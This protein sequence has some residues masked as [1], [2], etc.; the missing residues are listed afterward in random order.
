METLGEKDEITSR[1]RQDAT[2][3]PDALIIIFI[4]ILITLKARRDSAGP[5]SAA[6]RAGSAVARLE[7]P[8]L[9]NTRAVTKMTIKIPI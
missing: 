5:A 4:F 1:R 3:H 8:N 9:G 6:A 2:I 7:L